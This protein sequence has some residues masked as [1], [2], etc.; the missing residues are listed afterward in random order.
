MR[1]EAMPTSLQSAF[2]L[3]FWLIWSALIV[4]VVAL[5]IRAVRA[6]ESIAGDLQEI[7]RR[8]NRKL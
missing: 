3:I 4:Y 2:E 7:V 1:G 5:A 6:L 8:D